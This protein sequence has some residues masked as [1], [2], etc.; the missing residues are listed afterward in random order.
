VQGS[1]LALYHQRKKTKEKQN[2][3]AQTSDKEK[4]LQA[5]RG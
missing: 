5:S 4:S 1:E 3:I 2:H